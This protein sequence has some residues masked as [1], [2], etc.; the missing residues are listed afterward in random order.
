MDSEFGRRDASCQTVDFLILFEG[1]ETARTERFQ[2]PATRFEFT[3]CT[4]EYCNALTGRN[5]PHQ[6]LG[7]E[8]VLRPNWLCGFS[9]QDVAD[10]GGSVAVDV[11]HEVESRVCC[12]RSTGVL[13]ALCEFRTST[14][15]ERLRVAHSANQ[16]SVARR[17]A[18]GS[19]ESEFG[20]CRSETKKT[21]VSTS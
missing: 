18:R 15:G 14:A 17:S 6:K 9:A 10:D 12:R 7:K 5:S 19:A 1:R 11:L 3:Q 13:I 21:P 2:L 16:H 20:T 4:T 8:Q